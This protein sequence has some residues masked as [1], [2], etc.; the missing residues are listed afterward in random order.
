MQYNILRNGDITKIYLIYVNN[1]GVRK[2][3]NVSL[4][5]MDSKE[6]F[7]VTKSYS[8]FNKPKKKTPAELNV[9]T[10]DGVYKAK[11]SIMDSVVSLDEIMYTTTI[12]LVWDFVQLRKSTRKQV[13]LPFK[14]KFNDGFEVEG[15]S[16]DLSLNGISF[17]SKANISSIY[18]R[19]SCILS[20]SLP[21]ETIVNF[22]G[23]QLNVEA[24]YVR[25][26]EGEGE[27]FGQR[28]YVF[29][30]YGLG[31]EDEMVLKNF[32]LKLV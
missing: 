30:F 7:F 18:Q 16:F 12:P 11:V 19:L 32:L 10:P 3:E 27:F 31:Y 28:Y 15:M 21:S 8:T 24:K 29:K 17:Y 23:G 5:F 4:R 25:D 22:V 2:R 14:L 20:L 9:Y 13:E 1:M 26:K 6:S